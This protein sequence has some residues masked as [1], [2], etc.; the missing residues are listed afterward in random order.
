MEA[1]QVSS[2]PESSSKCAVGPTETSYPSQSFFLPNL[3]STGNVEQESFFGCNEV[4]RVWAGAPWVA[5]PSAR[6][7]KCA[8]TCHLLESFLSLV[9]HRFQWWSS[10][11]RYLVSHRITSKAFEEALHLGILE[12]GAIP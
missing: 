12:L 2:A 4:A 6:K 11:S 7:R 9:N 5:N 8:F 10:N 3:L 1:V